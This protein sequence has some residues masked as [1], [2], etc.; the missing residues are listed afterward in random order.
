MS[1]HSTC[2]SIARGASLVPDESLDVAY[3]ISLAEIE[4][5]TCNF[6]KKIGEGSF[7]PVYYGKMKEGKE[8]AVK[9]SSDQSSH[10]T[11]QFVNEVVSFQTLIA[12][13]SEL[14]ILLIVVLFSRTFC[15]E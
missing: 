14:G 5:G 13:I 15:L 10:G 4:E 11:Q 9:V 1:K 6:S 12:Y 3:Y 8:V 7:G 2:Y